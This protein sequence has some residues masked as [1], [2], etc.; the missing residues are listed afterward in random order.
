MRALYGKLIS[1]GE[2]LQDYLLLTM[3]LF[4]GY[5]FFMAGWGK[6]YKIEPVIKFFGS[7]GIPYPEYMAPFVA[8]LEL[9]GG[10]CLMIGL[11]S[12][13]IAIPLAITMVVALFTAHSEATFGVFQNSQKFVNQTPFNYLLT[14]LVVLSFGPGTFSLDYILSRAFPGKKGK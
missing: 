14:C 12:R 8:W 9:A 2:F 11:A 7:M 1:L 10:I 5:H 13:F 6:V 3:R 4:W